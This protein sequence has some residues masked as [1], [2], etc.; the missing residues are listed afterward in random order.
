MVSREKVLVLA[1]SVTDVLFAHQVT[2]RAIA[3]SDKKKI[4]FM[5]KSNE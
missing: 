3:S 5:A 4:F 1:V 2:T